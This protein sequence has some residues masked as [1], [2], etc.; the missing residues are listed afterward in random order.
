RLFTDFGSAGGITPDDSRITQKNSIRATAGIGFQWVS[1]FG[2]IGI[3]FA[4]PYLK[5]DFDETESVR[6]NFGARL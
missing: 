2:P 3:D 4:I 5:E 1:P 6:F